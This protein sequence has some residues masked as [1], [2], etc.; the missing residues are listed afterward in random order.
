[1]VIACTQNGKTEVLKVAGNSKA[2]RKRVR[3]R[4]KGCWKKQI[5]IGTYVKLNNIN[6]INKI[7]FY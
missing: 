2:K 4:R 7:I 1:M 5:H 3:G 6:N